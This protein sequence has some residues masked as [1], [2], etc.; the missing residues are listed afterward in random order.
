M[1][2]GS[3]WERVGKGLYCLLPIAH[4]LTMILIILSRTSTGVR[5]KKSNQSWECWEA[6][7]GEVTTLREKII[8]GLLA[9]DAPPQCGSLTVSNKQDRHKQ[10]VI[11]ASKPQKAL[12]LPL[13]S[14]SWIIHS[15]RRQ[16]PGYEGPPADLWRGNGAILE[17]AS[18]SPRLSLQITTIPRLCEYPVP[19]MPG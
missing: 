10:C 18:A 9:R 19:G 11:S 2:K 7:K 5:H 14:L 3:W 17:A 8:S 1:R 4:P 13:C 6:T 12:W 15:G 16:L